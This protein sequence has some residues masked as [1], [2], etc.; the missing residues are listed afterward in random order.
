MCVFLLYSVRA[1][2]GLHAYICNVSIYGS[3][4]ARARVCICAPV[5]V[6]VSYFSESAQ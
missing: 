2:V 6:V 1:C 3:V 4:L 5:R